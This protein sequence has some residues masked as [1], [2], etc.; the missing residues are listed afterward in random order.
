MKCGCTYS[1]IKCYQHQNTVTAGSLKR[2]TASCFCQY[3]KTLFSCSFSHLFEITRLHIPLHVSLSCMSSAF[4]R[5]EKAN[6]RILSQITEYDSVA[7]VRCQWHYRGL[8][9][10]VENPIRLWFSPELKAHRLQNDSFKYFDQSELSP[11]SSGTGDK[12]RRSGP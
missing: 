4:H 10:K 12:L 1:L 5:E 11:N 8:L 6:S 9:P 7:L 3:N 2:K